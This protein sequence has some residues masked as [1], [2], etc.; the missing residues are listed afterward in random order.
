MDKLKT[1]FS[2]KT[3]AKKDRQKHVL[4]FSIFLILAFLILEI[5]GINLSPLSNVLMAISAVYFLLE[6]W[7]IQIRTKNIGWFVGSLLVWPVSYGYYFGMYRKFL[8][9]KKKLKDIVNR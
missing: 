9:G 7:S 3:Q 2:L 6:M 5:V 8:T 4:D 1:P